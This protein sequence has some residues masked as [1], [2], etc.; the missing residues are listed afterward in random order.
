[1]FLFQ[2]ALKVE[3]DQE[4]SKIQ[5]QSDKL[6]QHEKELITAKEELRKKEI[7]VSTQLQDVKI[8][9]ENKYQVKTP[10][11][12]INPITLIKR[13]VQALLEKKFEVEME[14]SRKS[15]EIESQLILERNLKASLEL[16]MR[17]LTSSNQMLNERL[18][19]L[20][21]FEMDRKRLQNAVEV[22]ERDKERLLEDFERHKQISA[23][24]C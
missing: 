6:R 10:E 11:P 17:R 7:E 19:S 15:A 8:A 9:T 16:E 24:A 23:E 5:H 12:M 3:L 22:L 4:R 2:I 20:E 14:T 21:D 1:M 13:I 18:R